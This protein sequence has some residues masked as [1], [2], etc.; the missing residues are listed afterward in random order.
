MLLGVRLVNKRLCQ[1]WPLDWHSSYVVFLHYLLPPAAKAKPATAGPP[2]PASHGW[3]WSS[4]AP[5]R[6]RPRPHHRPPPWFTRRGAALRC[7]QH[8]QQP[9][10]MR[11]WLYMV[12]MTVGTQQRD[13]NFVFSGRRRVSTRLCGTHGPSSPGIYFICLAHDQ[14]SLFFPF[15]KM[16][17]QLFCFLQNNQCR[18][19][20]FSTPRWAGNLSRWA[21]MHFAQKLGYK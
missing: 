1:P 15:W 8:G 16:A 4:P 21:G 7:C 17:S 6:S 9:R 13:N 10:G 3:L 2:A 14:P 18:P 12:R 11:R 19:T 20:C 5:A